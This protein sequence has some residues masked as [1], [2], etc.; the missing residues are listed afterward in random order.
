[1]T[2]LLDVVQMPETEIAEIPAILAQVPSTLHRFP[3]RRVDRPGKL[4]D[5]LI[6]DFVKIVKQ[7]LEK[8]IRLFR[9]IAPSPIPKQSLKMLHNLTRRPKTQ[10][11]H[12]LLPI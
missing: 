12:D 7:H 3:L 8:Q 11:R 9:D 4:P 6:V 10:Q 5:R 1:M 2:V